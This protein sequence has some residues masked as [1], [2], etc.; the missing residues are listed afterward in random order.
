MLGVVLI[1][2]NRITISV[3]PFSRRAMILVRRLC[4]PVAAEPMMFAY[5]S[6]FQLNLAISIF[7]P[8]FFMSFWI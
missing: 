6:Q 4:A 3:L 7:Q 2:Q 1:C 5:N 8:L